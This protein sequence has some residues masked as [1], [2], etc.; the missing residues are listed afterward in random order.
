MGAERSARSE[1]GRRAEGARAA[2]SGVI[3]SG[4]GVYPMSAGRSRR[5]SR[6]MERERP[7]TGHTSNHEPLRYAVGANRQIA[8][9]TEL[10]LGELNAAIEDAA[11]LGATDTGARRA[12]AALV[13][14][15]IAVHQAVTAAGRALAD[16]ERSID[17]PVAGISSAA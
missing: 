16:R 9:A 7:T 17:V 14:A 5:H 12:A 6:R 2:H 4:S 15:R 13:D 8:H 11:R 1:H 10:L 3:R